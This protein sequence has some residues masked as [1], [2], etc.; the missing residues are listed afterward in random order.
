MHKILIVLQLLIMDIW[1]NANYINLSVMYYYVVWVLT[2]LFDF[3][4]SNVNYEIFIYYLQWI[5]ERMSDTY[6]IWFLCIT[7]DSRRPIKSFRNSTKSSELSQNQSS[8]SMDFHRYLL[9][10]T[11][12][13]MGR[14]IHFWYNKTSHIHVFL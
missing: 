1:I 2:H 10:F 12:N 3:N 4:N 8:P 7:Y 5:N 6:L 13:A 9:P 14:E 11:M